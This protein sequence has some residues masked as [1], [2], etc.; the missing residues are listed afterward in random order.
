MTDATRHAPPAAAQAL[1]GCTAEVLGLYPAFGSS[2][3]ASEV[4]GKLSSASAQAP[5]DAGYPF[6]ALLQRHRSLVGAVSATVAGLLA[7]LAAPDAPE[8]WAVELAAH[9]QPCFVEC[10]GNDAALAHLLM[11]AAAARP[12]LRR[13]AVGAMAAWLCLHAGSAAGAASFQHILGLV[14]EAEVQCAARQGE[15]ELDSGASHS[16]QT[17][18]GHPQLHLELAHACCRHLQHCMRSGQHVALLAA[19]L[20]TLAAVAQSST[21]A[22]CIAAN[23]AVAVTAATAA[24]Q[25]RSLMQLLQRL[26]SEWKGSPLAAEAQHLLEPQLHMLCLCGRS[27]RLLHALLTPARQLLRQAEA[28]NMQQAQN[29]QAQQCTSAAEAAMHQLALSTQPAAARQLLMWLRCVQA[30]ALGQMSGAQ[31]VRSHAARCGLQS[32]QIWP[33]PVD[34]SALAGTV[35]STDVQDASAAAS[36]QHMKRDSLALIAL[37]LQH[38]DTSVRSEAAAALAALGRTQP[39]SVADLWPW[40]LATLNKVLH[41][42]SKDAAPSDEQEQTLRSVLLCA[43]TLP[44]I[45]TSAQTEAPFFKLCMQLLGASESAHVQA[46]GL[47]LLLAFWQ[48]CGRG[49]LQLQRA[50]LAFAPEAGGTQ[51]ANSSGAAPSIVH[52]AVASAV[53]AVARA[54]PERCIELVAPVAA[55]LQAQ[56]AALVACGLEAAFWMCHFVRSASLKMCEGELCCNQ[57][58]R[59]L[60]VWFVGVQRLAASTPPLWRW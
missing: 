25:R 15:P 6:L 30:D 7:R 59:Q 53:A 24:E 20:R 37:L 44:H 51:S 43:A 33:R 12:A 60:G 32:Q 46:L 36:G 18:K 16:N 47:R 45:C 29:L 3:A 34:A 4:Q 21:V 27:H 14:I 13:A 5:L 56:D 40:C 10:I 22:A 52:R 19:A 26:A 41:A 38:P 35:D 1:L 55:M 39:A 17:A 28:A 54:A 49:W 2:A 9:L 31:L 42:Y 11:H 57:N 8:Q 48:G 50:L 23:A 58:F